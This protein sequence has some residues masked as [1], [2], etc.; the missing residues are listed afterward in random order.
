MNNVGIIAGGGKLPLIIGEN[1]IKKNFNVIF[2][3]L[4][5]FIPI[6]FKR[7]PKNDTSSWAISEWPFA[8]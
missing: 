7:R 5:D 3:I 4:E 6:Y 2:F 8:V 1:L